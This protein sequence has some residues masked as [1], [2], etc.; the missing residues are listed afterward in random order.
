MPDMGSL[1]DTICAIQLCRKG[2]IGVYLGGSCTE[3]DISARISVHI[4]VAAQ[5]DMMLAKP[6]MGVDEA[7]S[8]IANEQSR[9]L[10][11]LR[12]RAGRAATGAWGPALFPLKI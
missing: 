1:D 12:R 9:L 8:L 2:G 11:I 3:T 5:V 7:Y 4:A 10:A 6:G